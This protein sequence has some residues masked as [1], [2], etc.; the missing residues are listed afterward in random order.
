MDADVIVVGAGVAGLVTADRLVARG[1][2]VLVLEARERVGGRTLTA[3]VPGFPPYVVDQ[4]GQ[5]VGPGQ[6]LLYT[7]LA[8]F[9]LATQPQSTGGS[10]LVVFRGKARRYTGR[11]PKLD[12]LTLLDVG[13]TQFRFDRLARTVDLARPWRTPRAT[14]LDSQTFETWLRRTCFTERGRD[15]FRTA[16]EAVFATVPANL[17]L[18]HAL[19][20]CASGTSLETLISTVGG[21][22]QDRVV[23][24]LGTL[25]VRL[26][27]H[28]GGRVRLDTPVRAITQDETGVRVQTPTG[29]LRARRVVV[30]VPPTLAGRIAYTPALPARRDQLTQRTPHGGIIKCH[31]VYDT[32]FW[33]ADGLSAEAASDQGPVKVA[34]DASPA[35]GGGPGILLAFLD[36]P[37][38]LRLGEVSAEQRRAE[39]LRSL[40]RFVGPRALE[41]VAFLERDWNAEEWT[42]GCYGAHLPPG[43]WTQVGAALREPVGRIHWAGTETAERWCGYVDGAIASGERAAAEA[44]TA[45]S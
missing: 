21:A 13:Q 2:S 33:R 22:Q 39:V 7:E 31:A 3:D 43:A 8:R 45:L 4:G 16:C 26:A 23:E 38:S 37:E 30:A 35:G 40:S 1:R 36:G 44:H 6:E 34:F 27:A 19:F 17:S 24:G 20:Y 29:E 42:R 41:P 10:A 5:W 28:L 15:F 14:D 9:G 12:P 25:A 18:L 11:I 32:P